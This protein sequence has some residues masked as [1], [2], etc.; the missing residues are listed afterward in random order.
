MAAKKSTAASPKEP[1]DLAAALLRAFAT[2]ERVNQWML[3]A[4]DESI[5][6]MPPP[7]TAS[8]QARTIAGIV[9]HIHNV[10][11]MWLVVSNKSNKAPPKL[12]R[13]RITR[14][15]AKLGLAA[16]GVAMIELLRASLEGGGHVKDFKPD[17]V[18]FLTYAVAHEAHHRGQVCMLAKQLGKPL[19]QGIAFGM[20]E[21]KKRS[22]EA[23]VPAP[24]LATM[25]T[26]A[27]SPTPAASEPATPST[28]TP[29]KSATGK[30]ARAAK[31]PAPRPPAAPPVPKARKPASEAAAS[32]APQPKAKVAK[33]KG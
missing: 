8:N 28:A 16:S 27:P 4:I 24:I 10:R 32:A 19:P 20:W 14:D 31:E 7:G 13:D 3:D 15:Q 6:R 33:A 30:P 22:D 2:N 21:W 26:A 9:A 5:W 1:I 29:T 18:G 12:D 25:P 23:L 11:H 17:V